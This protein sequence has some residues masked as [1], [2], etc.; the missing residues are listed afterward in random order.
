MKDGWKDQWAPRGNAF[1]TGTDHM[2]LEFALLRK[3][4]GLV[5]LKMK[6][7]GVLYFLDLSH[8]NYYT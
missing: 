4:S 6:E 3:E 8:C 2:P 7:V 1:L 5:T